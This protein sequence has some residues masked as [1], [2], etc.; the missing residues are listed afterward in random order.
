[1]RIYRLGAPPS[2]Q[3]PYFHCF[4]VRDRDHVFAIGMENNTPYPI[5]MTSLTNMVRRDSELKLK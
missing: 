3:L 1:M 5:V 4:V 2:I